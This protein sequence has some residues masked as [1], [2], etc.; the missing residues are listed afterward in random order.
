[1]P[2]GDC[3]GNIAIGVAGASSTARRIFLG[4]SLSPQLTTRGNG[5]SKIVFGARLTAV[6]IRALLGKL[7]GTNLLVSRFAEVY[8]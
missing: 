7:L 5:S 2:A 6:S 4:L 8:E 1:M 3:P